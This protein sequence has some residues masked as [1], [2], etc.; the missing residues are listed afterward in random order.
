MYIVL[1]VHSH[2]V[3]DDILFWQFKVFPLQTSSSTV[4]SWFEEVV[5]YS[6]RR[7][8]SLWRSDSSLWQSHQSHLASAA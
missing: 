8:A 6:V 1:C 4:S 3:S 5:T 2:R 7:T